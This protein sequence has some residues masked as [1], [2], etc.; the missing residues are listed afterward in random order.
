[1]ADWDKPTH[2]PT[3]LGTFSPTPDAIGPARPVPRLG[4]WSGARSPGGTARQAD[5][6]RRA[7]QSLEDVSEMLDFTTSP[8][9]S[10]SPI[11]YIMST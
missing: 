4:L 8:G 2:I 5:T 11:I 1:M 6:W 3:V 9:V 10:S 7:K